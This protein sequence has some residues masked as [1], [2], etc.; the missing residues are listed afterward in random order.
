VLPPEPPPRRPERDPQPAEADAAPPEAALASSPVVAPIDPSSPA[1]ARLGEDGMIRLRTR[2][3]DVVSSIERR[4]QDEPRRLQLLEQ[5]GRLN[6]DAWLTDPDVVR[7]LE[8]YESV[9]ASL[10]D[11]VGR[12]RRRRRG[13]PG[14][15]GDSSRTEAAVSS[16]QDQEPDHEAQGREDESEGE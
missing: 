6:P 16:D 8:D 15:G 14:G 12:R 11:A 2:Y 13:R 4:T 5:A 1:L 3:A 10:R 7:G 9:L